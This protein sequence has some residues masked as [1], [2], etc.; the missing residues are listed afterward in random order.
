M[1]SLNMLNEREVLVCSS[2]W[3]MSDDALVMPH[4]DLWLL[5]GLQKE[6]IYNGHRLGH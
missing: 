3:T 1:Y 4:V 2:S 6:K 5:A